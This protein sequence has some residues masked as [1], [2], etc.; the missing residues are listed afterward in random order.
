M[1]GIVY[2][3]HTGQSRVAAFFDVC[4]R[5]ITDVETAGYAWD[6][7]QARQP[8]GTPPVMFR[9]SKCDP[10]H[11][12]LTTNGDAFFW[13]EMVCLPVYLGENINVDW[14]RARRTAE[15]AASF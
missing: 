14:K 8:D 3:R 7:E 11:R 15:S 6:P 10:E 5:E 9:M 2:D 1:I 13:N 4:H 12:G